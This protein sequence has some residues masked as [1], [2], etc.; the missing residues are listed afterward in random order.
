[1]NKQ[2]QSNL[3]L[4]LVVVV[5][6]GACVAAV[7][8]TQKAADDQ[9]ANEEAV[10]DAGPT[11]N[12][13]MVSP[14]DWSFSD[15]ATKNIQSLTPNQ[16]ISFG[17]VNHPTEANTAYFATI[18]PDASDETMNLASFYK[19]NT[20]DRTF[21]RVYRKSFTKGDIKG[22]Q[23]NA[24]YDFHVLGYDNGKLVVLAQDLNDSPGPCT[25]PL[26]LGRESDDIA[27]EMFSLDLSDPYAK[28]LQA[29]QVPNDVYEAASDKQAVCLEEMSP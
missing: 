28:G 16:T 23:P 2:S 21:E 20:T 22:I 5:V 18:A 8:M 17:I 14:A 29:Y 4:G 26:T 1:M 7:L 10:I 19:Y 27:R 12:F 11:Q 24:L 3:L 25:E 13:S 9:R 6:L 15:N